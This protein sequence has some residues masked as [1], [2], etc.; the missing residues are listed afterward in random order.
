VSQH[1]ST[2]RKVPRGFLSVGKR[3][4][5]RCRSPT[6]PEGI[7]FQLPLVSPDSDTSLSR[8]RPSPMRDFSD[9]ENRKVI[10]KS[11]D[12][13]KDSARAETTPSGGRPG[14]RSGGVSRPSIYGNPLLTTGQI[15][16]SRAQLT[17]CGPA[18]ASGALPSALILSR[19][20]GV[21]PSCAPLATGLLHHFPPVPLNPMKYSIRHHY[22]VEHTLHHSF[23]VA[24]QPSPWNRPS[25]PR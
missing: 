21:W 14:Q 25:H 4:Y 7:T 24:H 22:G 5:R 19:E 2:H 18:H 6:H 23:A 13:R 3:R 12:F 10:K 15:A 16:C 8:A 17:Q 1:P 11:Q 9:T 20:I